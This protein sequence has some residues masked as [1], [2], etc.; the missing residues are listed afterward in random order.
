MEALDFSAEIGAGSGPGDSDPGRP[1]LYEIILRGPDGAETSV[2]Q[3]FPLPPA[4]LRILDTTIPHAVLSSSA[5]L[6]R[7]AT[8]DELPVRELGRRL[9]DFLMAGD[10]RALFAAARHRAARDERPLRIVLR[11]RP[12]ELARLPWEFLFDESENSYVCSTMPL[13]RHPQVGS[14][15]RPLLVQ[16]PLRVL[17][18]AARPDDREPLAV[19]A[20]QEW[21]AGALSGLADQGLIELAWTK[22]QTWRDLRAALRGSGGPWHAF[23][24]IGHGGFDTVGQEGTLALAD[25][26]GGTYQLGAEDLAMMLAGH[27][28]LRL[29]VLNACETGRSA[30]RDPFSSVAGAL[31]RRGVTA[32][33]AMQYPISN[34]AAVEFSRTFYESLAHRRP[35]DEAVTEARQAI[36]LA[37]RRT[38]EWGTPVL[39]MRALDGHLFDI[40]VGGARGEAALDDLSALY[41][42]GLASFYKQRWDRAVE[43]FREVQARDPGYEDVQAKFA[44]SERMRR[45]HLLY[46][47]G[48]GAAEAQQWDAA[49]EHLEAVVASEPGFLDAEFRLEDARRRR[50]A[51][52]LRAEA[53]GLHAAGEWEAVVAV[54]TRLAELMP[55]EPDPDGV[56]A[57]ARGR[58]AN[59]WPEVDRW[60]GVSAWA[61]ADSRAKSWKARREA[62]AKKAEPEVGV[63]E[64]EVG[65]AEPEVGVRV[66][67]SP[68]GVDEAGMGGAGPSP[69]RSGPDRLA[70]VHF[71]GEPSGRNIGGESPERDGEESA[72]IGREAFVLKASTR[73]VRI[74]TPRTPRYCAFSPDGTWLAIGCNGGQVVV[75]DIYGGRRLQLRH[76]SMVERA[77]NV[78]AGEADWAS[79]ALSP[80]GDRIATQVHPA[81]RVWDVATGTKIAQWRTN[82]G[83]GGAAL[84]AEGGHVLF[85][86]NTAGAFIWD[87]QAD[88]VRQLEA[89]T[90]PLGT[91][92]ASADGTRFATVDR[93]QGRFARGPGASAS[94]FVRI[95]DAATGR[96]LFE[97]D[98]GQR[99]LGLALSPDN[100]RFATWSGR[101][102]WLWSTDGS[103]AT[104]LSYVL[105]IEKVAYNHDGS[106]LVIAG[107]NNVVVSDLSTGQLLYSR[108]YF[109]C[110]FHAVCFGPDQH[111]R[112]L[113]TRGTQAWLTRIDKPP[114][115]TDKFWG[116]S[117]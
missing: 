28:S 93:H 3:P 109:G 42:E 87:V 7:G 76:G 71:Y 54:G 31:M 52:G 33:V 81:V 5:Q 110:E 4:E 74:R 80:G 17:C 50:T 103:E 39:Y 56:V 57:D 53:A 23:H 67:D 12:P 16:P 66:A 36:R 111:A 49:V 35:V 68:G 25:E 115:E 41:V 72:W 2:V 51:A 92:V 79:V 37:Q 62:D 45:L 104:Q 96:L 100:S 26:D 20:E 91:V 55:E 38:L 29:V 117:T 58:L 114:E 101:D 1:H 27:H 65:V 8:D 70:G 48:L 89:Q 113:V 15:Q 21:L 84:G 83:W 60:P 69:V 19:R 77:E 11:I 86:G 61:E 59:T 46:E 94:V 97:R 22:G 64:P 63:A 24:F 44:Q 6:R 107:S 13:V 34:R 73:D 43:I 9:F 90:A 99:A 78:I 112:A 85:P 40:G 18:M 116:A 88:A 98:C 10:G 75:T 47:A 95:W 32:A 30:D 106:R 14:P 82:R 105:P 102:V 108:Q